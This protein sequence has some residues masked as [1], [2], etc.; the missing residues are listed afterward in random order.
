MIKN[1]PIT[2]AIYQHYKGGLYK[3]EF[4]SKHS[5]T[6]EDLVIYTSITWGTHYARPL[7]E[8]NKP[9]DGSEDVRFKLK[10][11]VVDHPIYGKIII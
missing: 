3:V 1:Y 10:S 2:G 11:Q 9:I 5:E 6:S 4:M 8:W 7:E